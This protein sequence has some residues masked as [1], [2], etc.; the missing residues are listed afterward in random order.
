MSYLIPEEYNLL[1]TESKINYKILKPII[2]SYY[3]INIFQ[4]NFPE[5]IFNDIHILVL[6][7]DSYIDRKNNCHKNFTYDL[8]DIKEKITDSSIFTVNRCK[9]MIRL[10]YN[11]EL[12]LMLEVL[13]NIFS[14]SILSDYNV[15]NELMS[16]YNYCWIQNDPDFRY[17]ITSKEIAKTFIEFDY[18]TFEHLPNDYQEDI[19][20]LTIKFEKQIYYK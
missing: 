8:E 3:R 18:K 10:L 1:P 15:I 20:L 17:N 14:E 5:S 4:Y 19:E 7:I 9:Q 6:L 13:Q 16:K 2:E 11:Y 12:N